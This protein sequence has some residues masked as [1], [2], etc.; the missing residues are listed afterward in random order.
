MTMPNRS[1]LILPLMAGGLV[2][3]AE[4]DEMDVESLVVYGLVGG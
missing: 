3:G 2:L 4:K 1:R